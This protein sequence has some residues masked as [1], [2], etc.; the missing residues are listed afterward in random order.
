MRVVEDSAQIPDYSSILH[1]LLPAF[2][3]GSGD[4]VA[5]ADVSANLHHNIAALR[6]AA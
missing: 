6:H 4:S 5:S 1:E 3:E 2:N